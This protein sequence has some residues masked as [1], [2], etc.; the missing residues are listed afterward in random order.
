MY[1]ALLRRAKGF[2]ELALEAL[3][4][5]LY[6]HACFFAEQ[7]VQLYLKALLYKYLGSYPRTHELRQLLS[8]IAESLPGEVGEEFKRFLRENRSRISELEDTYIM[9]R[10]AWK[11]YTREDA[12]E[13]IEFARK[14]VE[15][16]RKTLGFENNA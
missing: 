7:Y 2:Y 13:I 8:L 4:R 10:Y 5:G 15:K 6:D 12:V 16:T 11:T 3:N 1:E 9:T 14:L